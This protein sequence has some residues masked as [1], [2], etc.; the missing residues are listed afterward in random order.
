LFLKFSE[1]PYVRLANG[2]DDDGF[3]DLVKKNFISIV[4]SSEFFLKGLALESYISS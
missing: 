2:D 4:Y 3:K 1:G